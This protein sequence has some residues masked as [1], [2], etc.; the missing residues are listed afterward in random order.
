MT[1]LGIALCVDLLRASDDPADAPPLVLGFH[2]LA[3]RDLGAQAD[4]NPKS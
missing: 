3:T 1:R 2:H 4:A